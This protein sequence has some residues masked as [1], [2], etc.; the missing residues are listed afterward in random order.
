VADGEAPAHRLLRSIHPN[1]AESIVGAPI[2]SGFELIE[3]LSGRFEKDCPIGTG[4][5]SL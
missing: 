4:T 3:R 5:A 1:E 2:D